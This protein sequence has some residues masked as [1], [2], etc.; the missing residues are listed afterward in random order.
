M[1]ILISLLLFLT[2]ISCATNS[3]NM[4]I[5]KVNNDYITQ[6]EY[7]L[8]LKNKYESY[9]LKHGY[10]PTNAEMSQFKQEV[11]EQ[12]IETKFLN[13][14]YE[15]YQIT[16]TNA[17][18]YDSLLINVPK[19][20]SESDKFIVDGKF[21]Q[22]IYEKSLRTNSPYELNW[23]IDF[24][25]DIH[26]PYQKLKKRINKYISVSE[27][28]IKQEFVNRQRRA[29][30]NLIEIND[31]IFDDLT[32]TPSERRKYYE[33]NLNNYIVPA[34]V[35]YNYV[36]IFVPTSKTD[37]EYAKTRIDSIKKE[38]D[39]GIDFSYMAERCSDSFTAAAGGTIGYV[40]IDSLNTI[41]KKALAKVKEGEYTKPFLY[42]DNWIIYMPE[43]KY[44][45]L[46]KMKEIVIK[47]KLSATTRDKALN[48]ILDFR[49]LALEVGLKTAALEF[50]YEVVSV[51]GLNLQNT[52][53]E[54]LGNAA[55]L[56]MRTIDMKPG[57]ITEPLFIEKR[58]SYAI[59]EIV[60]A[61]R[62]GYKNFT[63]VQESIDN[64]LISE[65]KNI[66]VKEESQRLVKIGNY[67][68]LIK[69]ARKSNHKIHDETS[70]DYSS[71]DFPN[72]VVRKILSAGKSSGVVKEPVEIKGKTFVIAVKSIEEDIV[73]DYE[74]EKYGIRDDLLKE[75]K[76]SYFEDWMADQIK[77]TKVKDWR[78]EQL[79]Q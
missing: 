49:N 59:F 48:R 18:A 14:S 1:K 5:G 64:I 62:N 41:A 17:E 45:N 13:Q 29:L 30:I 43:R 27:K 66:A 10:S 50:D 35:A 36:K 67:D 12:L 70:V 73:L 4:Y 63:D 22:E 53:I 32:V 11:W 21:N 39:Y 31:D 37:L 71:A 23:A 47:P 9:N 44:S 72:D 78:P 2:I 56:I 19:E 6:Q 68:K 55:S 69:E 75:K 46:I 40:Q 33:D 58:N 52:M 57:E 34:E 38:L 26:I 61:Q 8:A 77:K 3:N 74:K 15:K 7:M 24:Y 76:L 28:E 42:K 79:L 16:A 20:F 25:R 51:D 65:M 54:G 60:K